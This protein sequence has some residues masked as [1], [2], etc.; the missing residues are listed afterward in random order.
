MAAN[1][2]MSKNTMKQTNSKVQKSRSKEQG[3]SKAPTKTTVQGIRHT[4]TSYLR[5]PRLQTMESDNPSENISPQDQGQD[6]DQVCGIDHDQSVL[7]PANQPL[8]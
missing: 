1:P 5:K 8:S 7:S 6:Q 2:G 4:I 3:T